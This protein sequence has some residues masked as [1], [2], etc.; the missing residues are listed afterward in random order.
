MTQVGKLYKKIPYLVRDK[1]NSYKSISYT[2]NI[3][4][5]L[6]NNYHL[7]QNDIVN[8]F[9]NNRDNLLHFHIVIKVHIPKDNI[10]LIYKDEEIE[11]TF[12]EYKESKTKTKYINSFM[13]IETFKHLNEKALVEVFDEM[14]GCNGKNLFISI[15]KE[16]LKIFL[17]SSKHYIYRNILLEK[18][19]LIKDVANSFNIS[20]EKLYKDLNPNIIKQVCKDLDI[21]YKSL[22]LELGYKPDTINKAA[23]TEKISEQLSKAIELYLEN[24][25]LQEDLK[26]F[27]SIKET[28]QNAVF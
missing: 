1:D 20:A 6:T 15:Q 10:N 12:E 11:F 16:N 3:I 2:E 19:V 7:E 27:N 5:E 24:L 13:F 4:N 17:P 26:K 23:S 25:R 18:E 9:S 22:A 8:V 14:I 21:T 28:L